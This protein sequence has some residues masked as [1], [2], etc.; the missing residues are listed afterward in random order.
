M[1]TLKSILFFVFFA[2]GGLL[3]AQHNNSSDTDAWKITMT[4]YLLMGSMDG[5]ATIGLSGPTE[6][7]ANFGDLVKSLRF[8]VMLHLEAQKGKWGAITDLTYMKLGSN[9]DTPTGGFL[10]AEVEET[11][12]ELFG[13]HRV[14]KDWGWIDFYGGIRLW[15]VSLNFELEGIASGEANRSEGWVDPVVG[16]RIIYNSSN[17]IVF[18]LRA[19]IGGMGVGSDFSYNIQ[20]GIG[21]KFSDMFTLMLQYKYLDVDYGNGEDG[22]NSFALNAATHGPLLGFVLQF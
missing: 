11:I 1:K 22:R 14:I 8:A 18:S 16:G 12:F 3:I 19:D 17:R 21:Y 10:D 6:F 2:G 4:P 20:S 13:N 5:E 7:E 15:N 9:I